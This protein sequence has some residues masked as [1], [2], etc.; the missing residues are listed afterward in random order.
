MFALISRRIRGRKAPARTTSPRSVRLGLEA[1]E[2]RSLPS[3]LTL[4]AMPAPVPAPAPAPM[5]APAPQ[6]ALTLAVRY[7]TG[8][9]ITLSGHLMGTATPAGQRI[10]IRGE[11]TGTAQT[12][13]WGDYTITLTARDLGLVTAQTTEVKSNV[14]SVT[15]TDVPPCICNFQ[16]VEGPEHRW[17]FRG[18]VTYR[19]PTSLAG[20]IVTFGGMPNSLK[21][22]SVTT[23]A[24]GNFTLLITLTCAQRDN[25]IATVS[26]I[27]P[28]GSVSK[29]AMCDVSQ[30]GS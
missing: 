12:D 19:G 6:A 2:D 11:A 16:C 26:C 14:A 22:Q 24:D 17:I 10:A 25:G 13:V 15:L 9:C 7:N 20:L 4:T 27:S 8:T 1:L 28:W 3:T 29:T 30:T 21:G 23:D 5:P 18:K